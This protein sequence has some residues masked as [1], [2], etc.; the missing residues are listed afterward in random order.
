M[1]FPEKVNILGILK[2]ISGKYVCCV[3][4]C[5]CIVKHLGYSYF[6][7]LASVEGYSAAGSE[8][9]ETSETENFP[10]LKTKTKTTPQDQDRKKPKKSLKSRLKTKSLGH[11]YEPASSVDR[12]DV[13]ATITPRTAQP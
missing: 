6:S 5:V 4:V 12:T 9:V 1:C 8:P 3:C 13:L 7:P 2:T 11:L 10:R